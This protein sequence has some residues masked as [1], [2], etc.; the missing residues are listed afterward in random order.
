MTTAKKTKAPA[1]LQPTANSRSA[2]TNVSATTL[3]TLNARAKQSQL[4]RLLDRK[5]LSELLALVRRRLGEIGEAFYDIGDAL[6]EVTGKELYR[7]DGCVSFE[8]WLKKHALMSDVQ[9]R[10]FIAISK[11]MSR[12]NALHA[13]PERAYELVRL[14][15][16][17]PAIKSA[18]SLTRRDAT[19]DGKLVNSLTVSELAAIRRKRRKKAGAQPKESPDRRAHKRSA[20]AL[21]KRLRAEG[22]EGVTVQA[23]HQDKRW[24]VQIELNAA[25]AERLHMRARR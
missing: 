3:T 13:G 16:E 22:A 4:K 21:Q 8:L 10:K 1:K 18:D 24:I 12:E 2:A 14:A 17:D 15:A 5:R 9:A 11:G 7:A 25:D 23:L 20:A 6:Q 19:I